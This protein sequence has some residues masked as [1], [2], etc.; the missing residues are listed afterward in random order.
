MMSLKVADVA[1]KGIARHTWAFLKI[2]TLLYDPPLAGTSQKPEASVRVHVSK[3]L[4]CRKNPTRTQKNKRL[5]DKI[6]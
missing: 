3:A 1:S 5:L 2:Q 4:T 6:G